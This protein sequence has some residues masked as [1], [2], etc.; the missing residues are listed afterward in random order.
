[1]LNAWQP[2]DQN[3]LMIGD[4]L[5]DLLRSVEKF[6]KN[7]DDFWA[8]YSDHLNDTLTAIMEQSEKFQ[9]IAEDMRRA[10]DFV[11]SIKSFLIVLMIPAL[12]QGFL[13]LTSLLVLVLRD[14]F[15]SS[16]NTVVMIGMA[17]LNMSAFVSV[18]I[19][20]LL[21]LTFAD[22]LKKCHAGSS[23]FEAIYN[24]MDWDADGLITLN[25][26]FGTEKCKAEVVNQFIEK[27]DSSIVRYRM[28]ID[29]FT[30]EM[31]WNSGTLSPTGEQSKKLATLALDGLLN[32]TEVATESM[33][34][35]CFAIGN[36]LIIGFLSPAL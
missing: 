32:F 24:P 8:K 1:M 33:D 29:S 7:H 5:Y 36:P 28:A 9:T 35:V 13:T 2:V 21:F 19:T 14:F 18:A 26:H 10:N 11:D 27:R 12:V 30:N 15:Q 31:T 6:K 17:I 3:T 25:G 20:A 16:T 23:L 4:S 34:V 22:V